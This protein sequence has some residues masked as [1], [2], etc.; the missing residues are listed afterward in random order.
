M[1]SMMRAHGVDAFLV[2]EAFMR[3][4]RIPAR[5]WLRCSSSSR[6]GAARAPTPVLIRAV[7][8]SEFVSA[9]V[10][11]GIAKH[12]TTADGDVRAVDGLSFRVRARNAQRAAR[13]LR[14]RQVD[15]AAA[16]RRARDR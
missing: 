13:P 10:A 2:G 8:G 12:W 11:E 4:P 15:D 9:I 14:L 16:H 1:S 7:T 3:A 5:R 6:Q